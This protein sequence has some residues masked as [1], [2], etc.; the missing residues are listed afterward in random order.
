MFI[1]ANTQDLRYI[2]TEALIEEAY[3]K[4]KTSPKKKVKVSELCAQAL[5]N[6]TTFYSHYDTIEA[7]GRHI[8]EKEVKRIIA[9]C[10][11]HNYRLSDIEL[12]IRI[13][14]S[15][16]LENADYLDLIFGGDI[17]LQA[18]MFEKEIM[19]ILLPDI[20]SDELMMKLRFA[21]GGAV[22]LMTED[23][24]PERIKMLGELIGKVLS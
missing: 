1:L 9:A 2:K 23:Q 5:I 16:V 24:S 4:L 7:L 20:K 13:V 18:A 17:A 10:E 11:L 3:I 15:A 8:C 6:K 21:I 19:L 22:R 14:V 12:V